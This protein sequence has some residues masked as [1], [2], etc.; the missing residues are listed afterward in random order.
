MRVSSALGHVSSIAGSA[1][2]AY[3]PH[4]DGLRGL[5][6]LVVILFHLDIH[7]L[8]GGYIGV[9]VFFVISGFLITRLINREID[10]STTIDFRRFY[11]RRIR[12]LFPALIIVF[13]AS[14]LASNALFF[15]SQLE[16]FGKSLASATLS[17]SNLHFW[18]E[19][20]YFDAATATKP[21]LHTWSLSVEEQFYM[22]WPPMLIVFS[23][24]GR[25][26]NLLYSAVAVL[27][28]FLNLVWIHGEVEPK[29]ASTTFFFTP[30]RCYEFM[31]GSFAVS[32]RS[33]FSDKPV[34]K[35]WCSALGLALILL[36]TV[37]YDESLPFPYVHAL[38]PCLGAFFLICCGDSPSIAGVLQNKLLAHIGLIS[39]SVYLVH[40]P[41]IVFYKQ[42]LLKS[43][44]TG[45]ERVS[46]LFTSLLLGHA[47]F[48]FV[49]VPFRHPG[50]N[51]ASVKPAQ[52]DVTRT[53]LYLMVSLCAVGI[54]LALGYSSAFLHLH[55]ATL[56]SEDVTLGMLRRNSF[57]YSGSLCS[58]NSS[59]CLLGSYCQIL[60]LSTACEVK[61]DRKYQILV[62]GD[63]H[64]TDGLNIMASMYRERDDVNLI[65]FGA[66]NSC[67]TTVSMDGR[68]SATGSLW[69]HCE[70]RYE[71][72]NEEKFVASLKFIIF[73]SLR[74]FSG[75]KLKGS[76]P[77]LSSL[78]HRNPS[79]SIVV[80]GNYFVLSTECHILANRFRTIDACGR[81]K[82]FVTHHP[83]WNSSFQEYHGRKVA[84]K[85]A[86]LSK[87][88]ICTDG[89]DHCPLQ[90]SPAPRAYDFGHVP[91][92]TNPIPWTYDADHLSF[93]FAISLGRR[94]GSAHAKTLKRIGLPSMLPSAEQG[95]QR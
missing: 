67:L 14:W 80:L 35:S 26:R 70:N 30:F 41:V 66:D 28:I 42:S 76:W 11:V 62:Y 40:W 64:E 94:M 83:F 36:P 19:S 31:I 20:G 46:L 72:L 71:A 52:L 82:R 78:V 68:V 6:V 58:S 8:T 4:I 38:T 25:D 51:T 84:T 92:P 79:I 95:L 24:F 2:T 59:S 32:Y 13:A 87:S 7:H 44:L 65:A 15:G 10:V 74:P 93:E 49:E 47:L 81:E 75:R 18:S 29:Y 48:A 50:K 85:Y 12:R 88:V 17:V 37:M 57:S 9:D 56:T 3:L 63:S 22:I 16:S 77:V 55:D 69:A 61:K 21:L 89:H 60:N 45:P 43:A 1:E 73:S 86:T 90:T 5:A 27:S 23:R 91:Q 53:T 33:Y 39:Y 54:Y 34:V